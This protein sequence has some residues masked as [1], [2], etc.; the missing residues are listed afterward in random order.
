M[1]LFTGLEAQP[2]YPLVDLTDTNAEWL[3]LMLANRDLVELGHK[4][5]EDSITAF[6]LF[7]PSAIQNSQRV[8]DQPDRLL[9]A[10]HGV[11]CYEALCALVQA[12]VEINRIVAARVCA[13]IS[14]ATDASVEKYI[15][16]AADRL[17][18]ELPKT[19]AVVLESSQRH[20]GYLAGFAVAGAA[21]AWQMENDAISTIY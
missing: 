3:S 4:A 15:F 1:S 14:R 20:F 10:D 19:A 17:D 2:N 21:M 9:A 18:E 5:T 12:D 7:H 16:N 13:V 6:R 11:A 8:F